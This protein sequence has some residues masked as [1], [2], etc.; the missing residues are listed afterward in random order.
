[1]NNKNTEN[2]YSVYYK[3]TNCFQFC[4]IFCGFGIEMKNRLLCP[5]CGTSNLCK[6]DE[7]YKGQSSMY[8]GNYVSDTNIVEWN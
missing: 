2:C 7:E 4:L 5:H 1:M 3:C 6:T 8:F